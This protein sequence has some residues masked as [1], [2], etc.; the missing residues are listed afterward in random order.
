MDGMMVGTHGKILH[1]AVGDPKP[2]DPATTT[3]GDMLT[4]LVAR[5]LKQPGAIYAYTPVVAADGTGGP[6][7][8]TTRHVITI[9][10][11]LPNE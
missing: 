4:D 3:W 11:D 8:G 5:L 9:V 1:K 2:F 6:L 7:P 10:A